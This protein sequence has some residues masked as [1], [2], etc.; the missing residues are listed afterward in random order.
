LFGN[1]TSGAILCVEFKIP[2][3]ISTRPPARLGSVA[4]RA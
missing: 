3:I 2:L 1:E 4:A